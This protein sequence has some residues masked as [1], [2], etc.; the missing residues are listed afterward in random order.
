MRPA[1]PASLTVRLALLLPFALTAGCNRNPAPK[2]NAAAQQEARG[3][4][5]PNAQ[6]PDR[7]PSHGYGSKIAWRTLEDAR[8]ASKASGKPMMIFVHASWCGRCK[9]LGPVFDDPALIA[10]SD[11]LVMVNLD[12]DKNEDARTVLAP[13]GNYVPRILFFNPSGDRITDIVN[14]RSPQF[15]LYYSYGSKLELL[16]A[17][18]RA[19]ED[20][21]LSP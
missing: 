5:D 15:P 14:P 20:T 16:A 9:E 11:S 13:D 3:D 12:Q 10:A 7:A 4:S 8:T 18:R 2:P 1:R 6:S 17:M 21:A 19:S